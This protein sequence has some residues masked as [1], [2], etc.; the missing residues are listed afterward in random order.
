MNICIITE[1]YY[2]GGLDTFIVNLINSWSSVKDEIS[3]VSNYDNPGLSSIGRNVNRGITVDTYNYF[4][5]RAYFRGFY[6]NLF[7]RFRIL[8]G[9]VVM[10]RVLL[11]YPFLAV[12][13][14]ITLSIKFKNSDYDRLLVVNGGYPASLV[15][16]MSVIAWRIAGKKEPAVMNFHSTPTKMK[17][18]NFIPEI[19][20]DYFVIKYSKKIIG[21]SQAIINELRKRPL[22]TNLNN[23]TCIHNGIEDPLCKYIVP[24]S[25]SDYLAADQKYCLML[26]S[27]D[28]NK[29]HDYLIKAFAVVTDKLPDIK[30][31]IFG[32]GKKSDKDRIQKKINS[33]PYGRNI[34]LG[35]F[36]ETPFFLIKNASILLV[37]SQSLESFGLIL[38]EAMALSTPIV[39]TDV[40]GIPE[41]IGDSDAGLIC[42]KFD[43]DCFGNSIIKILTDD[44]LA[45]KMGVRGRKMYNVNYTA[46]KTVQ[47]YVNIL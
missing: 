37:P 1:N 22:F 7:T 38:I 47:E 16:R 17:F 5:L 46:R 24:L 35:E 25:T 8:R 19:L 9:G 33:L 27:Y 4:F 26:A 23:I 29:G 6:D 36:I 41:V 20:V 28:E 43:T 44:T 18:Y 15:C 34:Y 11:E 2:R 40:G 31:L 10:L 45:H 3:L 39:S 21:V 13:Y 32:Y 12:W 14:T 42:S 30:L